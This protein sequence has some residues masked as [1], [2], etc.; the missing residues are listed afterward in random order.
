MRGLARRAGPPLHGCALRRTVF[1][2]SELDKFAP[3]VATKE[4]KRY[5]RDLIGALELRVHAGPP[6][7]DAE[8]LSAREFLRDN[9]FSP[10]SDYY[11]RLVRIQHRLET[12]PSAPPSVAGKRNYG[13]EAGGHWMQLQSAYDHV[14]VS[15][16]HQGE[17]NGQRGR[18]KIS[19]RFN[20]QGRID[21]VELKFLRSLHPRLTGE[22]RKLLTVK[23]YQEIRKDWG[24]AEAFVLEVLPRELVFLYENIFRCPKNEVCAWLINSG[25]GLLEILLNHLEDA[26]VNGHR[27]NGEDGGSGQLALEAARRDEVAMPILRKAAALEAAVEPMDSE[28]VA[29]R[30][31][32]REPNWT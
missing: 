11:D 22:I 21:F 32:R 6:V 10:A 20:G 7:R 18:I 12:R 23:G 14:I 28:T 30:Y 9:E 5:A 16:C 31:L 27:A 2:V 26:P 29:V 13:G 1:K 24:A 25:H 17:F 19:H 8:I 15:T 4:Q 3:R